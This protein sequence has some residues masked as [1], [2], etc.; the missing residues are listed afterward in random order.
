M[1]GRRQPFLHDRLG[2]PYGVVL[3]VHDDADVQEVTSLHWSVSVSLRFSHQ[4]S[5]LDLTPLST[6]PGGQQ[7]RAASPNQRGGWVIT[8][9]ALR[10]RH[11]SGRSAYLGWP[12]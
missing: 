1:R 11:L 12:L 6:R 2:Q 10:H 7:R 4:S 5:P 8:P 3:A 9:V